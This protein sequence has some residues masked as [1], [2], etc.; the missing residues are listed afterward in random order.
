[1]E[2]DAFSVWTIVLILAGHFLG[3]G[4][5]VAIASRERADRRNPREAMRKKVQHAEWRSHLGKRH[6]V[7]WI[8]SAFTGAPFVLVALAFREPKVIVLV[9][10]AS[11]CWALFCICMA[12]RARQQGCA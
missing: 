12:L 2:A 9:A 3:V 6:T 8:A 11:L 7:L 1:M 4:C 10:S 5:V